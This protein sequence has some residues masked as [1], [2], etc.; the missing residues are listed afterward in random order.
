VQ[1]RLT[2]KQEQTEAGKSQ[3]EISI[4]AGISWLIDQGIVSTPPW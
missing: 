2:D 4:E 1:E 3:K